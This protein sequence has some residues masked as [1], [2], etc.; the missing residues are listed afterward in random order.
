MRSLDDRTARARIRDEALRLFADHGPDGVSI[1]DI[2]TAAGVSPALV[3]RH[4]GAKEGLREA[5]DEHVAEIFDSLLDEVTNP[6]GADP[7]AAATAPTMAE[8]VIRQLPADSPIPAYLGRMLVADGPAGATLFTRL[9]TISQTAL[10]RLAEAGMAD[11]GSDPGVR[12]A[13]LLINDLAVLILRPHLRT[14]LGDD[15]LTEIGMRR[16]G[17]EVLSIYR[18]GLGGAATDD[19]R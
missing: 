14:V 10:A 5:V 17:T 19:N 2:A 13:F 9:Y 1:R 11:A 18:T 15:P 8:L 6:D 4:Y 16:W 7:F 12:A 3:M